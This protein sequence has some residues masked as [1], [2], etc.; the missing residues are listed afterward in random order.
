M[1]SHKDLLGSPTTS[2]NLWPMIKM[3]RFLGLAWLD[4]QIRMIE[5][6]DVDIVIFTSCWRHSDTEARWE[7]RATGVHRAC[8]ISPL[9]HHKHTVRWYVQ[10]LTVT[11]SASN[12]RYQWQYLTRVVLKHGFQNFSNRR[13]DVLSSAKDGQTG[14]KIHIPHHQDS[15]QVSTTGQFA[16]HQAHLLRTITYRLVV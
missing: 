9:E 16:D 4:D 6:T 15:C 10:A 11:S 5:N 2:L 7:G 1:G 8:G 3:G 12:V 13:W 14:T